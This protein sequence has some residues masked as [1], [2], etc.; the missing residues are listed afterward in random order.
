MH[1][2]YLYQDTFTLTLTLT[3][4]HSLPNFSSHTFLLL[5]SLGKR[6]VQAKLLWNAMHCHFLTTR[7]SLLRD[8]VYLYTVFHHVCSI[9]LC[10][11]S[12]RL[13]CVF[14][15]SFTLSFALIRLARCQYLTWFLFYAIYL[16]IIRYRNHF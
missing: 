4:T 5:V 15:S 11:S 16:F 8:F 10:F 7:L 14:H 9:H 13:A 3:Q 6:K 12:P 2:T 1:S